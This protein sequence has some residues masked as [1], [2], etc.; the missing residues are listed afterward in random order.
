MRGW[1]ERG[2]ETVSISAEL[3]G[4]QVYVR[5]YRIPYCYYCYYC[6]SS[7]DVLQS[8]PITIHFKSFFNKSL[9]VIIPRAIKA[10][11]FT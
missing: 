2:C 10:S 5:V 3:N 6:Y 11:H 7:I 9:S 8:L 1:L 4:L